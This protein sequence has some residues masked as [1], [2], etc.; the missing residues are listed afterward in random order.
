[1]NSL[2][3]SNLRSVEET[4]LRDITDRSAFLEIVRTCYQMRGIGDDLPFAEV[5]AYWQN[6]TALSDAW[7][8]ALARSLR[9]E[10]PQGILG[11]SQSSKLDSI[12]SALLAGLDP[13]EWFAVAERTLYLLSPLLAPERLVSW[14]TYNKDCSSKKIKSGVWC[15]SFVEDLM[16]LAQALAK[17]EGDWQ[18]VS[19]WMAN[20]GSDTG[21]LLNLLE[22]VPADKWGYQ[23]DYSKRLSEQLTLLVLVRLLLRVLAPDDVAWGS[24]LFPVNGVLTGY[25]GYPIDQADHKAVQRSLV[26]PILRAALASNDLVERISQGLSRNDFSHLINDLGMGVQLAQQ[27]EQYQAL[28]EAVNEDQLQIFWPSDELADTAPDLLFFHVRWL[29]ERTG[30]LALPKFSTAE[31][32]AWYRQR[33]AGIQDDREIGKCVDWLMQRLPP[34]E[35]V[36]LLEPFCDQ[37]VRIP[38]GAL[39]A[40]EDVDALVCFLGC[41]NT[42]LSERAANQLARLAIQERQGCQENEYQFEPNAGLW[43]LLI[44]QSERYAD[45]FCEASLSTYRLHPQELERWGLLWRNAKKAESRMN[46]AEA[47]F[48]ACKR[49]ERVRG[50]DPLALAERLYQD[51]PEPFRTFVDEKYEDYLD[52]YIAAISDRE[53]PL[54]VLIPK[55]A[56]RY[57]MQS[58]WISG[59]F[60]ALNPAPVQQALACYPEGFAALEDKAQ[61]KLLPFF[62]NPVVIACGSALGELLGKATK[63]HYP[64]V[65]Q[66]IARTGVEALRESGLLDLSGKKARKLM[67]TGLALNTDP[68]VVPLLRQLIDDKAHDDFSRGLMLDNLEARG[69]SVEGLDDWSDL[70]IEKVQALAAKQKIPAAVTKLWNADLAERLSDLGEP[71]GLYLLSLINGGD[72]ERLPRKARQVLGL[73]PAGRRADFALLGVNQWIADLGSDKLKVL[74]PPLFEYG[75]E[76]VANELVKACKAWKKTRKQKSSAAIRLLCRI[77][78][79]YGIAQAHALWESQQF[80]ESIMNNARMALTEVAARAGMSFQEFVDQLVPDFGLKPEGLVL[81]VGPYRY[82][83]KIKPDLSLMVVGPNGKATKSFP[84]AKADE[85]PDKRSLAENQFKGLRKNLKPVL[86][87]QSKRL[88]RGFTAGK[89][90]DLALWQRLFLDHPLMNIIA[91]GVVWGAEDD[92]GGALVRFRPS[93]T[94]ELID[95]E[96]E[97]VVLAEAKFIHMVHPAEVDAEER[98]AWQAHFKDYAVTSPIGQW[99]VAVYEASAEELEAERVTRQGGVVINRGTFGSLMEKWGYLKG[100]AED[101]AMVNGH[102]WLVSHGEW[103]VKC[104]HSGV[105][106]Y[107]DADEEV[108]VEA[109]EP[110]RFVPGEGYS[111]WKPVALKALP[112]ALRATLLAQAE[113]LKAAALD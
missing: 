30:K 73:I 48:D 82:Q 71:G 28:L 60:E 88:M 25:A 2:T 109:L 110:L 34:A 55:M 63:S 39:R 56:A 89:R 14:V 113:A 99:D 101:G 102:T 53:N 67:L 79:N 87:Q 91:Q 62:N 98:A 40:V 111:N 3:E 23:D 4:L 35:A 106:V 94:G 26:A 11:W 20:A 54:W 19:S 41:A 80:S 74:L 59:P 29:F 12:K 95:L 49:D 7:L 85:D 86:K 44:E 22:K 93:D 64:S 100:P 36:A 31:A 9:C 51:D 16:P 69:E 90:W 78:G 6:G 10:R 70:S 43:P 18:G 32:L 72:G 105:S 38:Y 76:R 103:L 47:L 104:E 81:D 17:G 33:L 96:D 46:I 1:M 42:S 84:K 108:S 97:S 27:P 75:D 5:E 24:W 37:P 57:L 8:D 66:M 112:I 45:L 50:V 15:A 21:A 83:V 58:T 68:D 107:F 61:F 52:K 65:V 13:S 92:D 77:P